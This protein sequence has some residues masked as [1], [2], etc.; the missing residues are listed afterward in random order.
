MVK[1]LTY[2]M[3]SNYLEAGDSIYGLAEAAGMPDGWAA[4]IQQMISDDIKAKTG[5]DLSKDA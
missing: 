5:L 1:T 3:T 4:K 2:E